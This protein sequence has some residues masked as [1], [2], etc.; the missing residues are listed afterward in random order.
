M[1]VAIDGGR[2][3]VRLYPKTADLNLIVR[4]A[5]ESELTGGKTLG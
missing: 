2:D 3:L 1:R 5:R 4:P